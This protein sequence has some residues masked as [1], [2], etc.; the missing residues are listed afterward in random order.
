MLHL[1]RASAR[2]ARASKSPQ[3]IKQ[4]PGRICPSHLLQACSGG[5]RQAF[6][7][8]SRK[9]LGTIPT[10]VVNTLLDAVHAIPVS[11]ADAVPKAKREPWKKLPTT[12][13]GCGA[14]S[15]TVDREAAGYY[16]ETRRKRDAKQSRQQEEDAIFKQAVD[17][18]S[19]DGQSAAPT[20]SP[21]V[22]TA[23]STPVCNR[24][25][26]L[27]HNGAGSSIIHPS[28][29]SIQA[30]IEESPHR[31]NHIYHVLD[32][33]D[34]PM[35][36]IPNL[37]HALELPRLRTQNRRS[38]SMRYIRGRVAEVSFIITRS[39]LLAPVKEQVDGLMPYLQDVLRDALGKSGQNVRLGNV[40]CVSAKRSWW[41][42]QVKEEIYGRGGA[43][44]MVGKVNV[45]KSALFESTFPKGRGRE[46]SPELKTRLD[47]ENAA[48][49]DSAHLGDG[50]N[51]ALTVVQPVSELYRPLPEA[52][53]ESEIDA[54]DDEAFL[55]EDEARLLPPAQPETA[56]PRMPL[57]SSL[58]GTTASPIRVPFGQG[59]GELIDLPGVERN[60]L[61]YH[62]LLR[63]RSDLVLTSRVTPEQH[64]IKPGQSLL[65][66]GLI[67]I[68]PKTEDLI[69]MMYPFLPPSLT[70][71]VTS[72]EKAIAIQTGF[73]TE[74]NEP[75]AGT[76]PSIATPPAKTLME[77]AGSFPLSTD[78]TKKRA[79]PVTAV[80]AG[81][82]KA[83]DLPYIVYA[84]DILLSGLGW[85]EV[86]AQVRRGAFGDPGK[87]PEV[88]VWSP[89]GKYVGQRRCM[90]GWLLGGPRQGP[91]RERRTRGRMSIDFQRR[92]AG[93]A[94]GGP[95]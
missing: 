35:S 26:M 64:V 24:C 84:T 7:H 81:K 95:G 40:R 59:K 88:E 39:D 27:H 94:R 66:G 47:S 11:G 58:P 42:K 18:G 65:L 57:I 67:R 93:G 73:F 60:T 38:K 37:Q 86:V 45:G 28:M 82:Q 22:A 8:G 17:N 41:T 92:K 9:Q 76:V 55:N 79:G 78:V 23:D 91:V 6:S 62:V 33:A 77:S 83:H 49:A 32:A 46:V 14:P 25:H 80:A 72:T 4:W 61:E 89:E 12:C 53:Q 48:A 68:T 16:G 34:F 13:P 51:D 21:P 52:Y 43:G 5:Y 56:Y 90:N 3:W 31:H 63:H 19:V 75:Y 71:H 1:L 87:V 20:K 85:V 36:L 54:L 15:Q 30:I 44:W 70:P 69:M 29:Q 2:A 74:T 50:I 10:A